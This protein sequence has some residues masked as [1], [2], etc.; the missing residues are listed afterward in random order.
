MVSRKGKA[1]IAGTVVAFLTGGTGIAVASTTK[2]Y[3]SLMGNTHAI[4]G[5]SYSYIVTVKK[6]SSPV[7][8]A[9]VSLYENKAI[10]DTL[11]TDSSGNAT[12]DVEFNQ[13]GTYNLY[14]EYSGTTSTTLA[15]T[16]TDIASNVMWSV[17]PE[18]TKVS[19][20]TITVT[21]NVT[22]PLG[23]AFEGY[24]IELIVNGKNISSA[25]SDSKGNFTFT[26]KLPANKST[27]KEDYTITL[28]SAS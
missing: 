26:Y 21:G 20:G 12:F 18:M 16:V 27:S 13:T 5:N 7:A 2:T 4:L 19:G 6:G 1:I 15:V 10:Y 24:A 25:K 28:G 22:D 3:V 17:T 9:S 8:N 11:T 23:N 14:A